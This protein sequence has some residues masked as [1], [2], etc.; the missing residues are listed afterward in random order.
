MV[1]GKIVSSLLMSAGLVSKLM[2]FGWILESLKKLYVFFLNYLSRD[3]LQIVSCKMGYFGQPLF[4]APEAL[5]LL[6]SNEFSKLRD[7]I[8]GVL[9]LI[10][11]E[12]TL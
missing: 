9:S 1:W 2:M 6:K 5:A 11:K 8:A 4:D 12:I 7:S 3:N 10:P